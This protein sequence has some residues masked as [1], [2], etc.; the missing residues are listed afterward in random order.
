MKSA[1][2]AG[3]LMLVFSCSAFGQLA[4]TSQPP[5]LPELDDFA[6]CPYTHGCAMGHM[7]SPALR[8][9]GHI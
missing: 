1:A 2:G 9:F 7:T 5:P 6:S 4:D 8:A 3:R